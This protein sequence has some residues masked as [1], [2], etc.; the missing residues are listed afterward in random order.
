MRDDAA[1]IAPP[2]VRELCG[3]FELRG[4]LLLSASAEC[5]VTFSSMHGLPET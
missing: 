4:P 2:I 5:L 3:I 1:R